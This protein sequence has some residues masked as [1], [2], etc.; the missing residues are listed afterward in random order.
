MTTVSLDVVIIATGLAAAVGAAL[1]TLLGAAYVWRTLYVAKPPP[2]NVRLFV[3]AEARP[4]KVPLTVTASA[5]EPVT[6]QVATIPEDDRKEVAARL[7]AEFPTASARALARVLA[8][9]PTTASAYMKHLAER[10]PAVPGQ[11][12]AGRT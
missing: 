1:G 11:P 2:V 8:V 9:S 5:P 4:V 12:A 10:S 7:L 6:V 3:H